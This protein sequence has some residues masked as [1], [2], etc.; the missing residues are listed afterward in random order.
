MFLFGIILF[1]LIA[2]SLVY[3][4]VYEKS[5]FLKIMGVIMA[6]LAGGR[7]AAI[8]TGLEFQV[9]NMIII[10]VLFVVNLAWLLTMFS[11]VI[12]FFNHISDIK[13]VGKMLKAT[14]LRAEDQKSKVALWGSWALPVYIWL[15]FPFT[16]SFA[17]A[18]IGFLMGIPLRRLLMVV[19]ASMLVGI[20][21]WTYG[22]HSFFGLVGPTGKYVTYFVV[23]ALIVCR[24]VQNRRKLKNTDESG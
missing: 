12:A 17:G 2:G 5:I 11:L 21:S 14:K 8:L 16:G 3:L 20:L 6:S 13:F 23:A 1:V 22:F 4:L 7:S 19:I 18:L 15:P 10:L 24:L 9:H